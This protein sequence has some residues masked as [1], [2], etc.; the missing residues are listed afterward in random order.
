MCVQ[1]ANLVTVFYGLSMTAHLEQHLCCIAVQ[2]HIVPFSIQTGLI[3][4]KSSI[5]LPLS[6]KRIALNTLPLSKLSLTHHPAR[7]PPLGERS[8]KTGSPCSPTCQVSDLACL[9]SISASIAFSCGLLGVSEL[10][11]SSSSSS[12][13]KKS[14]LV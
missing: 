8:V 2:C 10:I 6:I 9:A 13:V 3:A 1:T 12:G 4:L 14:H 5:E 7:L 11:R